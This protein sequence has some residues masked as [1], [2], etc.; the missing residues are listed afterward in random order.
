MNFFSDVAK[1]LE[2]TWDVTTSIFKGERPSISPNAFFP[3]NFSNPYVQKS[4]TYVNENYT[5]PAGE[6]IE[7]VATDIK[8]FAEDS[9]DTIKLVGIIG[10]ALIA[11]A[12]VRK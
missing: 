9:W 7:A 1:T 6:K 2:N 10:L 12:I 5:Y 11:F 4:N 8:N 3:T